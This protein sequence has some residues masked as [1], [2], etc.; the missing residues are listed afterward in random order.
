MMSNIIFMVLR[1]LNLTSGK[2]TQTDKT[3]IISINRNERG[4][5]LMH[6]QK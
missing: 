1:I 5:K 2:V 3:D 4:L 6:I